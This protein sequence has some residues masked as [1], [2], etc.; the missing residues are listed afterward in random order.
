MSPD[1]SIP[2]QVER[3]VMR[4]LAKRPEERFQSARQLRQA[5]DTAVSTRNGEAGISGV[6]K[7]ILAKPQSRPSGAGWM[8]A[9][10]ILVALAVLAGEHLVTVPSGHNGA[11]ASTGRQSE[12]GDADGSPKRRGTSLKRSRA[13]SRR[14]PVRP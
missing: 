11:I 8:R 2:W 7:T 4:A 3:V 13:A 6:E 5:L 10:V 12:P 1:A 9:V 14:H